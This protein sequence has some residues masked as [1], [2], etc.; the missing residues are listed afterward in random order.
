[1]SSRP[2]HMRRLS[3]FGLGAPRSVAPDELTPRP[4][5]N[6]SSVALS[7]EPSDD[8][9]ISRKAQ[10]NNHPTA[11][12]KL[13]KKRK[14]KP[15]PHP[16]TPLPIETSLASFSS[17]SAH[18]SEVRHDSHKPPPLREKKSLKLH[19]ALSSIFVP[20]TSRK[21]V[22]GFLDGLDGI[23]GGKATG[24][25]DDDEE[26]TQSYISRSP[27][28]LSPEIRPPSGLGQ[29]ASS[30][31]LSTYAQEDRDGSYL[32]SVSRSTSRTPS[33]S[34]P[35]SYSATPSTSPAHVPMKMS[36]SCDS[37]GDLSYNP[38]TGTAPSQS[39]IDVLQLC[40]HCYS[41]ASLSCLARTNRAF[42]KFARSALYANIN[43]DDLPDDETRRRRILET[44]V[45]NQ[46]VAECVKSM[47]WICRNDPSSSSSPSSISSR[48]SIPRRAPNVSISSSPE[49]YILP[50]V[51]SLIPN[52]TSLT[53]VHPHSSLLQSF[54]PVRPTRSSPAPPSPLALSSLTSLTL[55]GRTTLSTAFSAVL[56]RFL[57]LH[58]NIREL[59]LPDVFCLPMSSSPRT[60]S[61]PSSPS[62]PTDSIPPVP[63]LPSSFT[64]LKD[65]EAPATILPNLSRLTA[66]LTLATQLVPGRPV[67][68][69]D[70]ELATSLYEGLRPAEV[71]RA[72]AATVHTDGLDWQAVRE[73]QQ[74]GGASGTGV[75]GMP[76]RELRIRCTAKVDGRT[77][78]RLLNALGAELGAG[79]EVL[80][81]GWSGLDKDLHT[82]LTPALARFQMLRRLELFSTNSE[83]RIALRAYGES[84]ADLQAG[85][86]LEQ[87]L[88]AQW[89]RVC[90][91]LAYMEF[92]SERVWKT[93]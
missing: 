81:I 73:T 47:R 72:F 21:K 9:D 57:E 29:I 85:L 58:P 42:L 34:I 6:A 30:L 56:L 25:R 63:P 60:G 18:L 51:F 36:E 33:V 13:S 32:P 53:L 17:S 79:L 24:N 82:Q 61:S 64:F 93:N 44:L 90:P 91:Q 31:D 49:E 27:S 84:L 62:S 55:S 76:L 37:A 86:A 68:A 26:K 45:N 66:P 20:K 77:I 40:V 28:P 2:K 88:V 4:I 80:A 14:S 59:N 83:S 54:L 70:I 69:V 5:M 67:R 50:R 41:F 22:A 8:R 10:E 16:P 75:N 1:M 11:T 52:L 39:L 46:E 78:G 43:S 71:A 48:H 35:P 12:R 65:K 3:L 92:T 23:S 89:A 87:R 74:A 38:G 7:Q 19:M 15:L